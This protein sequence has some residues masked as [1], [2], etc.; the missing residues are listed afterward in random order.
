VPNR[1]LALGA[2]SRL[3]GVDPDTLRRWADAGR[4]RSYATPGGHRRF[5]HADL[6]RLRQR[7]RGPGRS[8]ETLGATPDRLA[9]AYARSYRPG[10]APDAARAVSSAD[11]ET[12]RTAG[13]E[14][15]ETLLAYLDSTTPEDRAALESRASDSVT[16]TA[17]RLAETGVP[18]TQAIEAFVTARRPLLQALETLGRRDVLPAARMT[19]LY[20][21]AAAI[22]DRLLLRFVAALNREEARPA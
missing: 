4:V 14:L 21:D 17:R 10:V 16:S 5:S 3:L 22:L 8:L 9:R 7:R 15:V 20:A 18:L 12:F 1:W 2:A 11:R 13:R 6:A 19:A